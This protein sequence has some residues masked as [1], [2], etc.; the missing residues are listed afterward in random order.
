[1]EYP[2]N[3][4]YR[5]AKMVPV[6]KD[7]NCFSDWFMWILDKYGDKKEVLNSLHA[8][9]NTFSWSGSL[10]PLLEQKKRCF[11]NTCKHKLPEVRKW[12]EFCLQELEMALKQEFT[13]EEYMRLHYN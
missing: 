11:E 6:F 4:P 7:N 1:M 5:I 3:A 10:I 2:D 13:R 12:S 9:M 8:N